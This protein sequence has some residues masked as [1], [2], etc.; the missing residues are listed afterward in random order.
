MTPDW[1]RYIA[2]LRR[3]DAALALKHASDCVVPA[4]K[5]EYIANAEIFERKAEEAE[6]MIRENANV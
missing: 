1:Y 5:A 2:R 6:R 4:W 3:E